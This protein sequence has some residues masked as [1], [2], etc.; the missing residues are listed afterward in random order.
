MA[1]GFSLGGRQIDA[2]IMFT[3]VRS[4]TTLSEK[5][6]PAD[7][8][9]LLNNYF[10]SIFDPIAHHGGI[11]NQIIGDGLMALF[12]I[13]RTGQ[14][15]RQQA[16]L[17]AQDML[18]ALEAFNERQAAAGKIQLKIGIGIASGA[19][20]AGYAGTQHRATYT[21]VGDTVN[22]AARIESHTKIA[23]CHILM[24]ATTRAGL[25]E[26]ICVDSLGEVIFKGKSIPV[27]IYS[28]RTG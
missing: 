27:Q 13:A 17:A 7:I 12:G 14:D 22:L 2:S 19:V 3:D 5:S 21:C 6:S 20:I 18:K 26:S 9:E 24:D 16:V 25:P 8:I 1:D 28:V 10:A 4:F 15:H 23:G 11:V